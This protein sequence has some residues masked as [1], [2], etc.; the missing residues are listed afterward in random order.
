MVPGAWW[1]GFGQLLTTAQGDLAKQLNSSLIHKVCAGLWLSSCSTEGSS[2][3]I[4][5]CAHRLWLT[6]QEAT[7]Y[8][9]YYSVTHVAPG[10]A[11]QQA[12]GWAQP[13]K[14]YRRRFTPFLGWKLLVF[15]SSWGSPSPE[16]SSLQ[17]SITP[18]HIRLTNPWH[19]DS[20][21]QVQCYFYSTDWDD[22]GAG[23]LETGGWKEN[24]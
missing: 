6:W 19:S 16:T 22:Y 2:R 17:V 5:L 9:K 21:F 20:W 12:L 7:F 13:F 11:K 15:F 8:H 1:D 18:Q 23:P 4:L 10:C 24:E 14:V 3:K